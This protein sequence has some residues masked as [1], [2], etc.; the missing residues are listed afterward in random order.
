MSPQHKEPWRMIATVSL[1]LILG[2]GAFTWMTYLSPQPERQPSI[3]SHSDQ[4]VAK[5]EQAVMALTQAVQS[6]Q[7]KTTRPEP[8]RVTAPANSEVSHS[9]LA[10]VIREEVRQAMVQESP[11]A[12]RAREE[13]IAEAKILN[14]P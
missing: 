3:D 10:Q 9:G 2:V 4:R 12:Q 14:S 5:L 1:G 8:T 6:S 13:A 11:E 7:T